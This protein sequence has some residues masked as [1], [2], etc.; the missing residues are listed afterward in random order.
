MS[1]KVQ[2]TWGT[3]ARFQPGDIVLLSRE[4]QIG[5][6]KA[7]VSAR[8]YAGQIGTIVGRK[9]RS[10]AAAYYIVKFSDGNVV[11]VIGIFIRRK[12]EAKG[13]LTSD[14]ITDEEM[15]DIL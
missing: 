9:T 15:I 6:T 11:P 10:M 13:E 12:F 5:S 4:M 14:N 2:K 7:T 3:K 8:P 1:G